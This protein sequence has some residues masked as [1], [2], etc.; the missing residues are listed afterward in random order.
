[1]LSEEELEFTD[2][3]A[4]YKFTSIDKFRSDFAT[5]LNQSFEEREGLQI[6]TALNNFKN[7]VQA[8]KQEV[9]S[10]FEAYLA[11]KWASDLDINSGS[12]SDIINKMKSEMCDDDEDINENTVSV[13]SVS[14]D[15]D[16][17]GTG[18]VVVFKDTVMPDGDI[19]DDE[20]IKSQE[21]ELI[22]SADSP[23]DSR[24]A[25]DEQFTL[26]SETANA[27]IVPVIAVTSDS[28]TDP[29]LRNRVT[30]G[31]FEA[32]DS[33]FTY[34]DVVSGGG[35]FS[36]ETSTV[37]VGDSALK[38][39]GSGSQSGEMKQD[40]DE[41]D[42]SLKPSE[43]YAI[44]ANVYVSSITA[45]TVKIR[46]EGDS[47]TSASEIEINSGTATGSWLKECVLELLPKP[48]PANIAFK[49]IVSS[50][51][52]GTVYVDN[53]G[54]AR[55]SKIDSL[56][57]SVAIF[58]GEEDFIAGSLPDKFSF[59]LTSDDAGLFQ[60][61]FRDNYQICLPSDSS[62]TISDDYAK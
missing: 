31:S 38:V 60:N 52:N 9:L 57:I 43:F 34:W 12:A 36:Q 35:L 18:A 33:G 19:V 50:D 46:L 45:G 22:C 21:V 61:Y 4:T 3:G 24:S 16:N 7:Y 40:L 54:L 8:F 23:H 27:V 49:I 10:Y 11:A 39:L 37:Y 32:Y 15:V 42:P 20:M 25:G 56:G 51:F 2:S 17:A 44:A 28:N 48:L 47:Y 58:Q 13:S 6:V 30:D 1:M 29:Y 53:L 41:L 55:P 59:S 26:K 14:A 62:P 5:K